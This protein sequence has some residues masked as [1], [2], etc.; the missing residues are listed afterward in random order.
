MSI[1]FFNKAKNSNNSFCVDNL[2]KLEKFCFYTS[3]Y[4]VEKTHIG[5]ASVFYLKEE[6]LKTILFILS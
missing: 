4:A 3:N 6:A 2:P 5:K 1:F